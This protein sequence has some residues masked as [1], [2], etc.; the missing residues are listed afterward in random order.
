MTRILLNDKIQELKSGGGKA[1]YVPST[2]LA[3]RKYVRAARRKMCGG[4]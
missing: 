1:L 3:G 4:S 2:M